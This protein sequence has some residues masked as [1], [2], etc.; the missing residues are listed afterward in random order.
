MRNL[1]FFVIG[2]LISFVAIAGYDMYAPAP[3]YTVS[4]PAPARVETQSSQPTY[5]P[6]Q[7]PEASAPARATK[8]AS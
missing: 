6:V 1:V 3:M 2:L 8:Q 4:S 5:R 7:K